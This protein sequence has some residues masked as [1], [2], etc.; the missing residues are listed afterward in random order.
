M[1][2]EILKINSTLIQSMP[3][4]IPKDDH[5]DDFT[6]SVRKV[7]KKCDVFFQRGDF[8]SAT[9]CYSYLLRVVPDHP[10]LLLR[11]A[12][13]LNADEKSDDAVRYAERVIEQDP[14][15]HMPWRRLP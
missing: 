15:S 10:G 12:I 5:A 4:G 9:A 2:E 8:R 13:T 1:F 14:L 7:V 11:M 3:E 6:E